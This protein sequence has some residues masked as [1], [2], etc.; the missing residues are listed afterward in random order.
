MS[1][2]AQAAHAEAVRLFRLR[3]DQGF[4]QRRNS[5]R[6]RILAFCC[7]RRRSSWIASPAFCTHAD[8]VAHQL[9]RAVAH[10]VPRPSLRRRTRA[11]CA[12]RASADRQQGRD[13][14]LIYLTPG[15]SRRSAG[16]RAARPAGDL[17]DR[18]AA[19]QRAGRRRGD[20]GAGGGAVVAA[21]SRRCS[22]RI[23]IVIV[24]R[25]NR[26]WRGGRPAR[27][28]RR[29]PTQPRSPAAQP[30]RDARAARRPCGCCRPT[31]SST[32]TNSASPGAG[33]RSSTACRR[34]T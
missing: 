16:H 25:G 15:R 26:R 32:I 5:V 22:T 4:K 17:A 3:Q 30:A 33:S 10:R 12:W 6:W 19:R 27:A 29:A 24:P 28:G 14:P 21:S 13:M 9:R 31:W 23:S 7:A 18:P 34:S 11:G 2:E 1:A 20:A 8:A